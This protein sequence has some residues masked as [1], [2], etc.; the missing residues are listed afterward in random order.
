MVGVNVVMVNMVNTVLVDLFLAGVILM[1]YGDR[2][3]CGGGGGWHW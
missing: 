1:G 3:M 2:D